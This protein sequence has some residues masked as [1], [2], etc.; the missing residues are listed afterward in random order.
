MK[1]F[2]RRGPR[3]CISVAAPGRRG[4]T[5][6]EL[7]VVIAIIAIL[8][9]LLLPAVQQ[10]RE[11]AR[12]T[13]C[14]NHLKQLGLALHNFESA[15]K[16]LPVGAESKQFPSN[17]SHPYNFYRWSV[18]AHLTPYLE[19]SNAYNSLNLDVPLF[20]PPAFD[21]LPQ[22]QLASGLIV[23]VF[24][25]PSDQGVSV[26]S[27]Y[28]VGA[29]GPTNYAGCAGTGVG[30][31]TPFKDE[32]IDGTFYV[33]SET[34]FRDFQD[35]TSNTVVMSESTLGTGAENTGD[36]MEVQTSPQTVFRFV[37]G[38]PL[39]DASC[40]AATSWNVSNRRGFMW[41]DGEYRCTL[42]NHYYMPNSRTPDCLGVSLDPSPAKLY[43]GY[44]WRTARSWHSGG[45]NALLG[46]GS[47]RFVS[48]NINPFVWRA[49][50]T[51]KGKE[52]IG[53]F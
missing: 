19:Q 33:N 17:P 32:G 23:P 29:L 22:N 31:G 36:P 28:G 12:R 6:I 48:E 49:L 4:F 16:K 10:A 35:G 30:G 43:T 7:L 24:L 41:V 14:K 40:D 51:I 46:D 2:H 21:V 38:T 45:V 13:E 26:S 20:A 52:V 37:S 27:G 53:E 1:T 44:G 50:A 9:A 5:L 25:C 3:E 39:T 18:L 11:A 42:Y 15:Y 8:V 47:V 34:R